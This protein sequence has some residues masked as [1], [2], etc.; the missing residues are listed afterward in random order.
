M[1][2]TLAGCGLVTRLELRVVRSLPRHIRM[3]EKVA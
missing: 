1:K 2:Q 3:N